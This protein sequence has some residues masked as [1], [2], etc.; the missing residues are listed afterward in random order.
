MKRKLLTILAITF[1]LIASAGN[2]LYVLGEMGLD[3]ESEN[4]NRQIGF[5][6]DMGIKMDSKDGNTFT[7]TIHF[8]NA[9]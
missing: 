2:T 7:A 8:W 1:S 9:A 5:R 4:P 6:P 3:G